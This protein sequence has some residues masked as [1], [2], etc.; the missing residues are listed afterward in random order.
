M[1]DERELRALLTQA[2]DTIGVLHPPSIELLDHH[3][4]RQRIALSILAPAA[5]VIIVIVAAIAL[6]ARDNHTPAAKIGVSQLTSYR[7]HAV[8]TSPLAARAGAATAW[9]GSELIFWGGQRDAARYDAD[10]A[11]YN[12]A[13][14]KWTKLPASP[15]S[16]RAV[17]ASVW[18]GHDLFV[19]GGNGRSAHRLTDGALYDPASHR[20]TTLPAAPMRGDYL[21]AGAYLIGSK[22]LL[23]TVPKTAPYSTVDAALYDPASNTWQ[24]LRSLTTPSGHSINF[25]RGVVA[26]GRLYLQLAWTGNGPAQRGAHG[27]DVGEL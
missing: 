18:T 8:P 11:A 10:G 27:V 25:T 5:A 21:D 24:Q 4:R 13:T 2:A 9:T 23:I 7:W 17:P 15:L 26:N 22:V 20:W 3:R 19:W 1:D 6:H 14:H 12:P 16:A